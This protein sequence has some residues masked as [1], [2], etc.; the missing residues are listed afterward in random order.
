MVHG[1]SDAIVN[2][3]GKDGGYLSAQRSYQFWKPENVKK[4]LLL[5]L[6][7]T[8]MIRL[9]RRSGKQKSGKNMLH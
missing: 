5:S 3:E 9:L 8:K 4:K 6:I 2:Y 1:K 7:K